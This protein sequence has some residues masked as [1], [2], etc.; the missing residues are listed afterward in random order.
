MNHL[1]STTAAPLDNSII[2]VLDEL[3]TETRK[4]AKELSEASKE[5][6]KHHLDILDKEPFDGNSQASK[7]HL[8]DSSSAAM[9]WL[10]S[11]TTL[12]V[13]KLDNHSTIL[14]SL[15]ALH[16]KDIKDI[17]T[18]V[19]KVEEE[20]QEVKKE[21][22]KAEEEADEVR[23]RGIK[24]NLIIS[25]SDRNG[26]VSVLKHREQM[27]EGRV[28]YKEDDL[29]MILRVM[30]EKTS[31]RFHRDEVAACHPFGRRRQEDGAQGGPPG[32]GG[33][34]QE[35]NQP[36]SYVLRIWNRKPGSN[37]ETLKAG[38]RTGRG[39]S[40]MNLSINYMLT[41]RRGKLAK[42]AR[43]ARKQLKKDNKLQEG[44]KIFRYSH[45]ENGVLRIKTNNGKGA[46]FWNKIN[47][48]P[49]LEEYILR[50]YTTV[51]PR[52]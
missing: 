17:K 51:Y 29:D 30:E 11:T 47:S 45:D 23:Q 49:H 25:S 7:K 18:S 42:A 13:K 21:V 16:D 6:N 8:K 2:T 26:D 28:V 5:V 35:Q 40:A 36:T 32:A 20:V 19:A 9:S 39:F 52:H 43:E 41:A 4:M 48:I 10:I 15:L 34:R 46:R 24:G 37:W 3:V 33:R 1:K 31:I 44:E 50:N 27:A 22:E 12:A 14:N 38:L